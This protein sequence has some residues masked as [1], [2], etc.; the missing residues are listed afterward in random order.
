MAEVYRWPIGQPALKTRVCEASAP[1]VG[2][3]VVKD[4]P[5]VVT[6]KWDNAL[7]HGI[8]AEQHCPVSWLRPYKET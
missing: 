1:H 4:G 6:V 8:P 3:T 5:Q 7:S 2:G